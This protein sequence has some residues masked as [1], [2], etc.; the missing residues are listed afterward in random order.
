MKRPF[1]AGV[2]LELHFEPP[3]ATRLPRVRM[4]QVDVG[5][6]SPRQTS[7]GGR[8]RHERYPCNAARNF[9]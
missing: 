9:S 1:A 3:L 5:E 2:W 7:L 4:I 8:Y 6:A